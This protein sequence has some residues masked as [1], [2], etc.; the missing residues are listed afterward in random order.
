MHTRFSYP[1][2][3][4][5]GMWVIIYELVGFKYTHYVSVFS[6]EKGTYFVWTDVPESQFP[7]GLTDLLHTCEPSET[8]VIVISNFARAL[9]IGHH[10]SGMTCDILLISNL[11]GI[12]LITTQ[13]TST[14]L[15]NNANCCRAMPVTTE[16]VVRR[17]DRELRSNCPQEY[18]AKMQFVTCHHSCRDLVSFNTNKCPCPT[19]SFT[20]HEDKLHPLLEALVVTL[21]S[22]TSSSFSQEIGVNR[23]Y[24]LTESQCNLLW[25][26]H[27]D[28]K[29]LFIHGL[30]GTGKT[31]MAHLIAKRLIQ[32]DGKDA[33]LYVCEN[34]PLKEYTR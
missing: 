1:G 12:H 8:G 17:L 13:A 5:A 27:H 26:K 25:Q 7:P 33:V 16:E 11:K 29:L 30:A 23:L 31:L 9:D 18:A 6:T 24:L 15:D 14:S 21:S 28:R 10:Q 22:T 32:E 3:T 20:M 34:A 2:M 4:H 19:P